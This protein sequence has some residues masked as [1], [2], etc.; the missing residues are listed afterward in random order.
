[1]YEMMYDLRPARRVFSRIG[2]ALSAIL[3]IATVLQLVVFL[4]PELIWGEDNWMNTS[5]WGMWI[6]SFLPLYAVA[7]P[8]GVLIMKGAPAYKVEEHKLPAKAFLV[9]VPVCFCLMYGGNLIG[10]VLSM[11]LSGGTAENA[12]VDYAM[13]TNPLKI[14]VIVILAPLLEEYVCRKQIIDRTLVY[15]EKTAVLLSALAFGLLHQNLFQFFYAFALGLVFAYLYTRTG[16]LRY[17]VLLHSIINFMGSVVAPWILSLLDPEAL[18]SLDPNASTEELVA[19]MGQI[20]PGL[21]VY[22]LYAFLLFGLSI[23][24]LV[25]LLVNRKKLMWRW[26]AGQ[27]PRGTEAK[28]VYGNAGMVVY[29]V[30]CLAMMVLALFAV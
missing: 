17:P 21:L 29:T 25:L 3:V 24:G 4:V 9:I 20:L 10:T 5:S 2:F 13:D 11:L 18:L 14:L 6:G 26:T 28:T 23:A 7:I 30:L 1:M 15:G 16:R 12:L 27:L 22:F 8:L 19:L